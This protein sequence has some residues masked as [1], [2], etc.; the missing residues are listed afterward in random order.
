MKRLKEK[1]IY[2][3]QVLGLKGC[4]VMA[5]F[6]VGILSA[7]FDAFYVAMI[8]AKTTD[9]S[10]AILALLCAVGGLILIWCARI[11]WIEYEK[12]YYKR[13]ESDGEK[14]YE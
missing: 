11:A 14:D 8:A 6:L 4:A 5:F 13:A 7:Y 1:A 10:L 2:Q 3:W 12:N 9:N